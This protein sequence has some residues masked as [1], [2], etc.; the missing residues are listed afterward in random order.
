MRLLLGLLKWFLCLLFSAK[1]KAP[2]LSLGAAG[3]IGKALVYFG[4]KGIDC[5]R[6]Y[7]VPAN[8]RSSSQIAQRGYMTSAVAAWHTNAYTDADRIAWNRYAGVLAAI[9]SGF[10]AMVRLAVAIYAAASTWRL[11]SQVEVDTPT[12]VGFDVDVENSVIGFGI[13]ARIGTSKTH[14]PV[15]VAL[16]DDADGTYSLTWAAGASG[17]DYYV[18]L[19]TMIVAWI[20]CSGI[21]H[22]KTA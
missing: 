21:Y 11:I 5:V 15:T 9:M 7:V 8:P 17:V 18:Y 12:A 22:V 1:L 3:Q 19:E 6:E 13:R 16:V 4:W 10:N 14:F 2:L 20:R